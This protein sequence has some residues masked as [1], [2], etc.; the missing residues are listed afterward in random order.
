[1]GTTESAAPGTGALS[2]GPF[3]VAALP[4][5]IFGAGSFDQL[6]D[7]LASLGTRV[8]I[9]T[10]G[11]S[12]VGSERWAQLQGRLKDAGLGWVQ[13][14]IAGEPSPEQVDE[15]VGQ[16]GDYGIDM[17]LG[18]GGGSALDA[19]K[20]IAGLLPVQHSVMEYLEGVGP[21]LPY[22]GPS[23]P[24]VAVPTTAGTGSE[25]TK[26]A[27]LTRHGTGGFKKSFRD[28]KLLPRVALVDP[29]LLHSC[30]PQVLM[31]NAMDALTQL[32][33]SYVSTR[34]SAFTDALAQSGIKAF[35]AG[36]DPLGATP[37]RDP[38]QLA[39]AAM[40]SGICLA[41][42][43]LGS[44]HGMAS[45]LGACFPI[46]HGVACGTLLAMATAMN[47][48]ALRERAPTSQ[49]LAKYA[50][51]AGWLGVEEDS[52]EAGCDALVGLL[53]SWIEACELPRLSAFGMTEADLPGVIAGSGGNSMK[54][55]PIVL[56]DNEIRQ[57]LLARL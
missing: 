56:S 45:P 35:A 21:E 23:L 1:M 42:A 8:L 2:V 47:I 48:A 51:V 6:T 30:P 26:N 55:N 15:V 38:G 18:I 31:A 36:F 28:E 22:R 20:A 50:R 57:A 39:Y 7:V 54:T 44:V 41:Q 32:L 12:F 13:V 37:V 3:G 46:P 19:A 17:V 11:R 53:D 40:L 34:A 25:M 49:A 24:L 27:V 5:I 29:D 4:R 43:G 52:I 9:V 10:G 33:E 16:Y 14:S